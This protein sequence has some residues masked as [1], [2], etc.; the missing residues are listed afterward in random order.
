ISNRIKRLRWRLT[1]SYTVATV[2]TLLF[3]EFLLLLVLLVVILFNGVNLLSVPPQIIEAVEIY[4]TPTL[5]VILDDSP[6]DP[7][8]VNDW[9]ERFEEF[10]TSLEAIEGIPSV[11]DAGSLRAI[12]VGPDG[13]LLG[14]SEGILRNQKINEPFNPRALSGSSGPLRAA[15]NGKQDLEQLYTIVEPDRKLVM[16]VPVKDVAEK[17]VLGALIF[18]VQI[19]T[20]IE[21]LQG[22]GAV[23]LASLIMFTIIAAVTGT[24]FGWI[25]ARGLV[26]RLDHLSEASESWSQGDFSAK[27]DDLS[28]DE[29]GQLARR[30]NDMAGQLQRLMETRRELVVSEER[31]R[32]ARDLHDSVKQQAFAAASQL[33]TA[34]RLLDQ[35]PTAAIPHID[36]AQALTDH[37]RRELTS[38]IQE[39]RPTAL[40]GQGLV[41]ALH[42]YA[43]DWSKQNGITLEVQVK[44]ERPLAADTEQTLFR[45]LQE[46]LANIARHS[47]AKVAEINLVYG[48]TDVSCKIS[49]DGV[50]FA[51]GEGDHG[52]G[53]LSMQERVNILGGTWDIE[54]AKDKGTRI[55][56]TIPNIESPIN[57]EETTI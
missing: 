56:M 29:L 40:D 38:L 54:S 17:Q 37:L 43:E 48:K 47:Q 33:G 12:V 39:L 31:N 16:A 32:L 25:A 30:L 35:D 34:R 11:V 41:A 46:A 44:G 14:K 53:L 6:P 15:L 57:P 23:L 9:L 13:Q 8:N 26:Q 7:K 4:H 3:M 20:T 49:D 1:L 10:P 42:K 21:L 36:E 24:G 5:R 55:S 2:G 45:I 18:W 50:G 51:P 52:F 27:V 19:P 22:V 28:A